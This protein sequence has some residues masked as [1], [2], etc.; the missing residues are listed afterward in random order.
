MF[1]KSVKKSI[2]LCMAIVFALSIM[3]LGASAEEQSDVIPMSDCINIAG[4]S[5]ADTKEVVAFSGYPNSIKLQCGT[6][7]NDWRAFGKLNLT[8]YEEILANENT[9]I[10]FEVT[11]GGQFRT[12]T[13]TD[14]VIYLMNDI[15]DGYRTDSI[16]YNNSVDFGL[17][18][19]E[20]N[21]TLIGDVEKDGEYALGESYKVNIPAK[22]IL[23]VLKQ[24]KDNS[25]VTLAFY[26]NADDDNIAYILKGSGNLHITYDDSKIDNNNYAT[27]I[28]NGIKWSDLSSE[29][30]SEVTQ[31]LTLPSKLYGADV[32][33]TSNNNAIN[34]AGEVTQTY[35]KENV[36]LTAN[37]NY[38]GETAT[39]EFDVTVANKTYE[40]TDV[41]TGEAAFYNVPSNASA[42][43]KVASNVPG[44]YG[45][46]LSDVVYNVHDI[47]A[48]DG[49][50][51]NYMVNNADASLNN[52]VMEFSICLP[53]G[54]PDVIITAGVLNSTGN[55]G[56]GSQVDKTYTLTTDG[57]FYG[58]EKIYE[59]KADQWYTMAFVAPK[60]MKTIGVPSDTDDKT[61]EVYINGE[62]ANTM[63]FNTPTSY[64]FRYFR[65]YGNDTALTDI[66]Y[67]LDNV[68]WHC[69]EYLPKYD[70]SPVVTSDY[71]SASKDTIT[72]KEATV[73]SLKS[74]VETNSDTR[75]NVYNTSGVL[76]TDE[77]ANVESGYTLVAAAKN[78]S[79][80]ERSYAYYSIKVTG[81][82]CAFDIP[83]IVIDNNVAK[84]QIKLYNNTGKTAEYVAY[85]AVYDGNEL[86]KVVTA[87]V[88]ADAGKISVTPIEA[89]FS[90]GNTAKLMVWE[91][92][93]PQFVAIEK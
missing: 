3:P 62:L 91:N 17:L 76:I 33:W 22:T 41:N 51:L 72:V 75:L 68:R 30:Q 25:I 29:S 85:L 67:Y 8:G 20:K 39:K 58:S 90:Q 82:K 87:P 38:K 54:S 83:H 1:I 70:A 14:A 6:G 74:L 56:A 23:N 93:T 63:Q 78:G 35:I 53:S 31:K 37:V 50:M 60:G 18:D 12:H 73:A 24:G 59:T 42:K 47:S 21:G 66:G 4:G 89:S 40:F 45:K 43:I 2:A 77:N 15:C 36:I 13:Q 10:E 28:A 44:I 86:S 32:T 7:G 26:T 9:K 92:S 19:L 48:T 52:D 46:D 57:F 88:T 5:R 34:S 69:G 55:T 65:F 79:D 49:T 84:S 27:E 71:I 61:G 64:G 81:S 80:M 16:T 11:V